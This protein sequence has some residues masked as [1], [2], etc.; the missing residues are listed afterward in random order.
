MEIGRESTTYGY[1]TPAICLDR[2]LDNAKARVFLDGVDVTD[3]K[4]QV[5]DDRRGYIEC[6]ARNAQGG[7]YIIG[8][9]LA[10]ERRYGHVVVTFS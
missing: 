10:R 1:L 4:V 5:A 2:G 8:G 7:H 3:L 9:S 6:L